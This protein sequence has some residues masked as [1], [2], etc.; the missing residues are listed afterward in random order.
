MGLSLFPV[1][2]MPKKQNQKLKQKQRKFVKRE[3]QM[4]ASF[5]SWT[6]PKG[7]AKVLPPPEVSPAVMGSLKTIKKSNK[8]NTRNKKRR[9]A[10]IE[11]ALAQEGILQERLAKVEQK[12]SNKNKAKAAW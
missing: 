1:T 9:E 3:Q 12:Q 8:K 10:V 5:E 11:K 6:I 4:M 7:P 2:D